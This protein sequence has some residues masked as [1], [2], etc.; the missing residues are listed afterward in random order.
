M[1]KTNFFKMV[2][3]LVMAFMVTGAF[4][5]VYEDGNYTENQLED[6]YQTAGSDFGLYVIPDANYSPEYTTNGTI[7]AGVEWTWTFDAGL[8]TASV[9]SGTAQSSN[10]VEFT[11]PTTTGSPYTVDVEES[12]TAVA[13]TGGGI[14]QKINVI[15]A[16]S[17]QITTSDPAT[18]CGNQAANSVTIEFTEDVPSALAGYAFAVTETVDNLSDLGGSPTVNNVSSTVDFVDYPTT[19]KLNTMNDLT[20]AASPYSYSFN[21]SALDLQNNKITRYTYT[22]VKATDAPVAA[23][24]GLISAISQKSEYISNVINGNVLT[25]YSFGAKT[26]YV[27]I[28]VPTPETGPIYHIPNNFAY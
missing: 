19:N 20:G 21:T 24:D 11:N 28:V 2:M 12:N 16:P 6:I 18:A 15:D 22:I 4:A 3:T 7:G 1:K 25:T 9:T 10:Y 26:T 14:S 27:A 8:G 5:Q 13:C 17:A 23:D